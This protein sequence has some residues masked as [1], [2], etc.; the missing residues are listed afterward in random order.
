MNTTVVSHKKIKCT[1]I[2]LQSQ[3]KKIRRDNQEGVKVFSAINDSRIVLLLHS[4]ALESSI[5]EREAFFI[6][7]K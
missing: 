3:Q 7:V 5:L 1:I 4:F 2:V 6:G